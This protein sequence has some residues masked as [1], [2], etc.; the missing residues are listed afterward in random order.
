M[1]RKKKVSRVQ[2]VPLQSV[3]ACF[4]SNWG[5]SLLTGPNA[6]LGKMPW[7]FQDIERLVNGI[8]QRILE[9]ETKEL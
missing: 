5:D 4:P 2:R 8:K 7:G 6:A 3:L 1:K 9:L